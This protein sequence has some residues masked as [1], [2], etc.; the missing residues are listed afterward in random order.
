MRVRSLVCCC[1]LLI[2]PMA[3]VLS[4]GQSADLIHDWPGPAQVEV[5]ELLILRAPEAEQH[6]WSV[7]PDEAR[8]AVFEGGTI[9]VVETATLGGRVLASASLDVAGGLSVEQHEVIVGERIEPDPPPPPPP[10]VTEELWVM[11]IEESSQRTPEQAAVLVSR[12]VLDWFRS[13]EKRH[14]R[15]IDQD[16]VGESDEVPEDLAKWLK[17]AEGQSLPRVFIINENGGLVDQMPLP[18]TPETMI[19]LLDQ[20]VPES[21]PSEPAPYLPPVD[22]PLPVPSG[23][24]CPPGQTCPVPAVSQPRR[25][26]RWRR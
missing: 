10:P 15:L 25:L 19:E 23:A 14:W 26:L 21:E 5:G 16:V 13:N 20:Y 17:M 12:K 6:A 18:A 11:V 9:L 8:Y 22:E 4:A 7:W 3:S 1:L 2:V 24:A